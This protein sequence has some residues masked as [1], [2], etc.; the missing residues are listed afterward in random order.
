VIAR[1]HWGKGY[2]T[3]AARCCLGWAVAP[4]GRNDLICLIRPGNTL[5]I[6][7]AE[8]LAMTLGGEIEIM[9]SPALVFDWSRNET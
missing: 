2:A 5:S 8:K 4:L 9:G 3:E 7:V 1:A 6:R